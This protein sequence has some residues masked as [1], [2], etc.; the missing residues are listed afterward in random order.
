MQPHFLGLQPHF[1]G[2][3]LLPTCRKTQKKPQEQWLPFGARASVPAHG[4]RSKQEISQGSLALPLVNETPPHRGLLNPGPTLPPSTFRPTSNFQLPTHQLPPNPTKQLPPNFQL[5]TSNFQLPTSN[6]QLPTS[7]PPTSNFPP[8]N[9]QLPSHSHPTQLS[10]Q[11]NKLPTHHFPP[12]PS[13]SRLEDAQ[14]EGNDGDRHREADLRDIQ[15]VPQHLRGAVATLGPRGAHRELGKSLGGGERA[16]EE[17]GRGK[18]G[19]GGGG[20][21][22]GGGTMKICLEAASLLL[23]VWVFFATCP[24]HQNGGRYPTREVIPNSH[25][26]KINRKGYKVVVEAGG[27]MP[28]F[29]I[30]MRSETPLQ[31]GKRQPCVTRIQE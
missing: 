3:C 21:E 6:F 28:S 24:D 4:A 31:Q 26:T 12:S 9:F 18:R 22:E 16:G 1:V 15:L 14:V 25:H 23:P 11:P 27:C 29:V 19:E 17:G 20:G 2:F 7:H 13:P 5:P 10:T 30:V 8:T